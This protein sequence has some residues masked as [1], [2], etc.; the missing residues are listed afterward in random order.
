MSGFLRIKEWDR[1]QHYKDR[2]PP[3]I[4]LHQEML[5]SMTWVMANDSEKALLIAVMLLAARHDNAIPADPHYI[6]VVA[7]LEK[8][9][10]LKWLEVV[11]FCES[12]AESQ[13]RESPWPSRYI[14]AEL[15]ERVLA[16]DGYKCRDCQSKK[17]LEIDHIIPVSKGGE[18]IFENLQTLCRSCNRKKR[19]RLAAGPDFVAVATQTI[20]LCSTKKETEAEK[21]TEK[22]KPSAR[23]ARG[24]SNS[25]QL[26]KAQC[27]TRH[28]RCHQLI[29]GW[30]RDWAGIECPW[31]GA[32]GRQ[33]SSLLKAWPG[34]HDAEFM[35]C[36]DNIAQSECIAPGTRPCEWLAKLPKFIKGPLDQYWKSKQ[37]IDGNSKAQQRE[38][39][40]DA[41]WANIVADRN[42][43]H[44]LPESGGNGLRPRLESGADRP[45]V[46]PADDGTEI[47]PARNH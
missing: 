44:A 24:V 43:T 14:S 26:A 10:D 2:N 40:R 35:L 45:V 20:E 18:S 19:T 9:P 12:V 31:N 3:W 4:K 41:K 17:N 16:R 32:E 37:V 46:E 38:R 27:E 7:H 25:S 42:G 47:P 34:A 6:R 1:F 29:M 33:L 22:T 15:K 11:D 36:L 39:E 21:E 5:T 13:K 28:N 30:Y 8:E 23:S